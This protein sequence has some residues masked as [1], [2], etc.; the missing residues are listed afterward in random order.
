M[1]RDI[2]GFSFHIET[3]NHP[4]ICFKPPR[5]GSEVMHKLV[6]WLDENGVV[7][8]Y[9]GQWGILMVLDAKTHQ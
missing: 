4:P 1:C 5:Y 6:G 2:W 3:G 9:D 8:E 7:E